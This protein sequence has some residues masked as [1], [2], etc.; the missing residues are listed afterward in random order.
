MALSV[1]VR[2]NILPILAFL[3]I[4]LSLYQGNFLRKL[5]YNQI[6]EPYVILDEHTNIWHGLTLR[7]TG[8]PTAWSILPAY[9][10]DSLI[11]GSGGGIEGLNINIDGLVPS[12]QNYRKI[13]SPV[14]S[15]IV[16]DL[17]GGLN[18][19]P[20]VQPYLDH[21]PFGA[22]VLS[23]GV[24]KNA[25]TFTDVTNFD[26]RA[27]SIYLAILTQVMIAIVA[28]QLSKNLLVAVFSSFI[29]A[30]APSYLL[31][32]R[33]AQ[34]ENVLT[35][36]M[37]L[38]LCILIF[39]NDYK[40]VI[41]KRYLYFILIASGI[42]SGFTA[43]T[44]I[45]GWSSIAIGLVLLWNWK[46]D[47]KQ[48]MAFTIPAVFLGILY[49]VWGFYLSPK[50]F[51][52][53]FITQGIERGFI[54][55]L[56]MLT[57]LV[58]VN[59]LNFPF[60]GWWIGGFLTMLF[61]PKSKRCLPLY[62][63]IVIILISAL[64]LVGSNYPWYFIPLIPFMCIS[65]ALFLQEII[66]KPSAINILTLF[67]VFVSS[68]FY[69]G[70]GVFYA[71]KIEND[72]KQPFFLYRLSFMFFLAI[73]IFLINRLNIKSYRKIW[74]IFIILLFFGLTLLNHHGMYFILDNWGRLPLLNTPGTF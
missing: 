39:V 10:Q 23:L 49:F 16:E 52:D 17:G 31:L 74:P 63:S 19:I 62:I 68:S 6:P 37:L 22:L 48:I 3:L 40:K 38:S 13:K 15:V 33:Y 35:P 4:A 47:K 26:M 42:L 20:M 71:S 18:S 1:Y 73:I 36:L 12:L 14:V 55:S 8:I 66:Q 61:L 34:L 43:L 30:T 59:I 60:D 54:G 53:I 25:S 27:A 70:Y 67:F 5:G 65:T 32:S 46:F 45:A 2:K 64:V 29:Y 58:K 69:W 28:Y 56:N 11:F 9:K 24:N 50:L 72:F 57:T 44:K 21:P 41:A 7:K 51:V